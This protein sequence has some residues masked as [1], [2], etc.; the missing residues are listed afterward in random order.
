MILKPFRLSETDIEIIHMTQKKQGFS[1]E[2]E[3]LRYIV[4]NYDKMNDK[5][6]KIQMTIMR[7]LEEKVDILLDI[8]NTDLVKRGDEILYPISMVESPV[9]QQ[10]RKLRKSR[11]AHQKQK[12]DYKRKKRGTS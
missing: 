5:Q 8:A 11:L 6:N 12:A 10:S 9:I 1:S 3:A 4:R 2:A 7:E